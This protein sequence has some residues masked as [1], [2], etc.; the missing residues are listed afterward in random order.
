MSEAYNFGLPKYVFDR[1]MRE[2]G[3][4]TGGSKRCQMEGCNGLRVCVRWENGKK[5]WPC[6]KGLHFYNTDVAAIR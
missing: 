4:A 2:C 6:S 3:V 1:D 5:T